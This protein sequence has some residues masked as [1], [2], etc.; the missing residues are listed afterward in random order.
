MVVLSVTNCPQQLRGD[1]TKWFIE[2]DIGVYVGKVSARVREKVWSRVCDNIKAG[3]A[4]MVY[5]TNSE[6]GFA[7]LTHNTEWTPVDCEGIW[8][9]QKNNHETKAPAQAEL[10]KG[11][12]KAAKYAKSRMGR[13][14]SAK[15]KQYVILDVETTGLNFESDRVIEVG[16]IRVEDSRI[17]DQYQRFIYSDM[18]LPSEIVS[19]TGITSAMINESGIDERTALQEIKEFIG[20]SM[21]VG[22]NVEFD[23]K[24]ISKMCER[25]SQDAFIFKCKDMLRLVRRKMHLDN[26]RLETVARECGVEIGVVHRALEDC[27]IIYR[28][29]NELN[30][31]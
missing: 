15:Q 8:L 2:I 26:Y 28:L 1:L 21:I 30:I 13:S 7:I 29:N 11:F 3:K 10:T 31:F 27:K 19:M 16:M 18:V 4:I 23:I 12:S 24:F 17:V 20:N 5:S 9:M 14:S 6:Q 25:Q 22:Y